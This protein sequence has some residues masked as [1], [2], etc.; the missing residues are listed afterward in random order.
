M[1]GNLNDSLGIETSCDETAASICSNKIILSNIV[2]SQYMHSD[3]GGV[4][5]E[6]ASREHEKYLNIIVNSAIKESGIKLSNLDAI[7]VTQGRTS[8][9]FVDWDQLR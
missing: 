5:P 1:L 4:V 9:Y 3:Y 7:A 2:S 8:W 6:I